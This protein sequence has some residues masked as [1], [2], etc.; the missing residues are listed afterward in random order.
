M[1]QIRNECDQVMHYVVQRVL[2]Q[3][4]RIKASR[5]LYPTPELIEQT[6]PGIVGLLKR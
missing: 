5:R 6:W 2:F 4:S 1:K 3:M